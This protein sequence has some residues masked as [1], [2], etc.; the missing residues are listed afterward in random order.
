MPDTHRAI[1]ERLGPL[2]AYAPVTVRRRLEIKA[3][4][5]RTRFIFRGA[6]ARA[7][8]GKAFGVAFPTD[9][10][11]AKSKED[12]SA[13]W[14]GPDEW[15]LLAPD[16]TRDDIAAAF[17][18]LRNAHSAVDVSHRNTSILIEGALAEDVLAAGCPLDLIEAEFPVG[19]CTRT[20]IGKV[21]VVLWRTAPDAFH[22]E[23][24]RSFADYLFKF[25]DEAAR[26]Y[27]VSK[28]GA[29]AD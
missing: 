17:A 2:A 25:F 3:G 5:P 1:A 9:A 18:R 28:R 8:A 6:K 22:I 4:E 10:C 29:K 12:R 13:L 20:V 24:W 11:R 7:S 27:R 21:E 23:V 15:L 26:E 14:L 16:G 19:M